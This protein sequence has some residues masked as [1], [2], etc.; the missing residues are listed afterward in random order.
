[1][2]DPRREVPIM[3]VD[4]FT[5]RPFSGNPAAVVLE[6]GGLTEAMMQAIA[7]EMNLSETAFLLPATRGDAGSGARLL[8]CC[9]RRLHTSVPID[10]RV[11]FAP[12]AASFSSMCS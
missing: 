6:P 5:T 1:M 10:S 9:L 3:V 12:R 7:R 2:T 11:T 8:R 4:A